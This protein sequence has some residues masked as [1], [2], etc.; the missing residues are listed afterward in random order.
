MK[1]RSGR[2][3]GEPTQDDPVRWVFKAQRNKPTDWP[4]D[5][6]VYSYLRDAAQ[7]EIFAV[8]GE[9][10]FGPVTWSAIRRTVLSHPDKSVGVTERRRVFLMP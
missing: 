3:V 9:H 4:S 1:L 10:N 5:G 2:T 6:G 8:L 7:G